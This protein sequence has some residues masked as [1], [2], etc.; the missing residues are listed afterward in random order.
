MLIQ[1]AIRGNNLSIEPDYPLLTYFGD[2][3]EVTVHNKYDRVKRPT[4]ANHWSFST[5]RGW[6]KPDPDVVEL[7]KMSAYVNAD[8]INQSAADS[9]KAEA[10]EQVRNKFFAADS[11]FNFWKVCLT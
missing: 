3:Y 6:P 2:E 9:A 1:H 10:G 7:A 5:E 11:S 8:D 4:W